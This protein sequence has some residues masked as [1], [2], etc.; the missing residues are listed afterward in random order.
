[1]NFKT[2]LE[3]KAAKVCI[4]CEATPVE[5]AGRCHLCHMQYQAKDRQQKRAVFGAKPRSIFSP[6]ANNGR[7]ALI[8]IDDRAAYLAVRKAAADEVASGQIGYHVCQ[9]YKMSWRRL[10]KICVEHGVEFTRHRGSKRLER[11]VLERQVRADAASGL[12]IKE[13]Q[14]KYPHVGVRKICKEKEN[15]EGQGG[16]AQEVPGLGAGAGG[17]EAK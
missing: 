8:L 10:E 13:L 17:A 2:Q 9:K 16:E 15:G 14:F 7:G 5:A 6:T 3:R 11:L 12:S 4:I 1:M